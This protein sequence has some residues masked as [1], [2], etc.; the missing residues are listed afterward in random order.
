MPSIRMCSM[1]WCQRAYLLTL[2][3]IACASPSS[4]GQPDSTVNPNRAQRIIPWFNEARFGMFIHWGPYS[5]AGRS[6]WVLD[7][8]RIPYS[9]YTE[10]YVNAFTANQYNPAEWARL[11]KRA[12]MK[13]VVLTTKHSDGFALWDSK[14]S[15]YTAMKLGPKRDLVREF[16]EAVRKEGLKVG[17]YY[18]VMDW[19]HPDYPKG[20]TR[21][22]NVDFKDAAARQRFIDFYTAQVRE[23]MT[24]YGKIDLLWYD[25]GKPEPLNGKAVSDMARQLQPGLIVNDRNGKEG[26][27]FDSSSENDVKAPKTRIP[28]EACMKLNEH[29]GYH[30]DDHEFKSAKA[31]VRLLVRAAA[32]GGNLLLN[33]GPRADG[34]VPK[35]YYTIL[36]QVGDWLQKNGESVYDTDWSPFR[37]HVTSFTTVKGN[38]IYIHFF[39]SPG[40]QYT[41]ADIRNK[42]ISV[43]YA[44]SG[45]P[46]AFEQTN[47]R[48]QLKGLPFPF[49]NP[50]ATTVIVE[51]EGF[52]QQDAATY[53]FGYEG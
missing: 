18:S 44:H 6:E 49:R 21:G 22:A 19:Y 40:T 25:V 2:I 17:L 29:W 33:V 9:E 7:R 20:I 45:Q 3:V 28:W 4:L 1:H 26:S 15:D 48:L 10:K 14:V 39:H 36:E 41:N 51:V 32:S 27:D 43:R 50:V 47:G 52:P 38:R 42:V 35:P 31:V 11:A 24:N 53:Q 8:E 30:A 16:V 12:G 37:W 46:I 23:L 5:A 34:S 13:Y